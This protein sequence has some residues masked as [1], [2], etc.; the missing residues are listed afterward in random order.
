MFVLLILCY[1]WFFYF[2]NSLFCVILKRRNLPLKR[3]IYYILQNEAEEMLHQWEEDSM[4]Y[5]QIATNHKCG[6]DTVRRWWPYILC[7]FRLF[8]DVLEAM[9]RCAMNTTLICLYVV[10]KWRHCQWLSCK[11]CFV[12]FVL[13]LV[14]LFD[15]E[16]VLFW[17]FR[18]KLEMFC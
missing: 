13:L 5:H 6:Y 4:T 1:S 10:S 7:V 17:Q 8:Y 12:D 15:I 2:S 18:L 9:S 16:C 11:M 3:A 14:V